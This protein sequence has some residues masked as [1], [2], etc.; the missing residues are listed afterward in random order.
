MNITDFLDNQLAD[1]AVYDNYRAVASYVDGLK[2]SMRKVV[3]TVD[4]TNVSAPL[5]VEQLK[6]RVAERTQYL[7]G[8]DS[9][10]GVIVGMARTFPGSNNINVMVPK[11]NFGTRCI[12]RA[13]AGRYIYTYKSDRFDKIF[14]SDDKQLL[15]EQT[16]E[17]EKIEP[18]Y[19]L[20]VLPLLLVNGSEGVGNGF[21]QKILPRSP[22]NVA[23][24]VLTYAKSGKLPKEI[25]P[26]FKGF[27]GTVES[28]GTPSSWIVRGCFERTDRTTIK[29]TELPIGY[30]LESYKKVLDNLEEKKVIRDYT[31][32]SDG[33]N[34]FCFVVKVDSDF[35]KLP[36]DQ[37][38]ERLKLV[39]QHGETYNCLDENNAVVEFKS[40]IEILKAY[41]DFRMAAYTDRKK[42]IVENLK[43]Q[44][45]VL[46]EKMKFVV[47]VNL[48]KVKILK[49]KKSEI[50]ESLEKQK[51]LKIDGSFDHLIGMPLHSLTDEKVDEL[52]KQIESKQ[53]QLAEVEV[54]TEVAMW[55]ED[56]RR[57]LK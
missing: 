3:Y 8:S 7:H 28:A 20:P 57:V 47:A 24:A 25:K 2:P 32:K 44:I 22:A 13:A 34:G 54:K 6:S 39:K 19:Y 40:E 41:C 46:D 23:E 45:S 26:W 27:N 48:G 5:K 43:K 30:S 52:R 35:V 1:F 4:T 15:K 50:E 56:I 53:S 33:K 36:D 11:G 21:S 14:C 12:P 16:F 17:G 38:F 10:E 18:K 55:A 9:L 51:F 29:I 31:D 42:L 49:Q 37:I